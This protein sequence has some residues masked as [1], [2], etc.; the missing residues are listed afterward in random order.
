MSVLMLCRMMITDSEARSLYGTL[1]RRWRTRV[2]SPVLDKGRGWESERRG[3]L[4]EGGKRNGCEVDVTGVIQAS[5][6]GGDC[7]GLDDLK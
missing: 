3:Q 7:W 1:A 5:G 4:E 6:G 2:R